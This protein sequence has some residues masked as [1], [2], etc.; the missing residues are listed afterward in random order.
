MQYDP[1][2]RSLGRVFNTSPF[3][4]KIFYNLLDVLLLRSWHVRK[5][6]KCWARLQSGKAGY[7]ILDAGSGFG[8]YTW[9]MSKLKLKSNILAVDVKDE[10]IADCNAFFGK[11]KRANVVFEKA[12]LTVFRKN[13]SFDL[14]LSVDVMEHIAE[15]E[16]VFSNFYDSLKP[17]GMLLVSTPSDQGGSDVHDHDDGESFI[18]EHVRDGYNISDIQDKLRKA[19]FSRTEARYTYGKPG[20]L[21]WKLSMKYPILMLNASKLFFIILPFYYLITFPFALIF[22]CIDLHTTHSSGTGLLVRAYKD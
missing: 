11:I 4:R 13:D 1:I 14:I 5:D 15:D 18:D 16:K 7:R 3:L 9:F 21:G 12:D 10:Q 2:K 6:L 20:Q 8:Q 19:G 17:N 22:N